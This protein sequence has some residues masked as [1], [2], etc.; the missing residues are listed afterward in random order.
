MSFTMSV[1]VECNSHTLIKYFGM[2][3]LMGFSDQKK[4]NI[5]F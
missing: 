1:Q 2:I 4:R 3:E 5:D